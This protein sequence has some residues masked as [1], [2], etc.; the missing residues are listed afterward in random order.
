MRTKFLV[1]FLSIICSSL[2][3]KAQTR[4]LKKAIICLT[5]DD[6]LETQLSTVI[7]QLDS[8]GLK[9]TFFLNSINGSAVSAI[10]GKTPEA[11]I[12]WSNAAKHGHELGNHTLFHPCPEKLGWLKE[13]SIDN[14][15]VA[16]IIKE[17]ST[18][19]DILALL[20]PQRKVRSFAFPC[21]NVM[22]RD[23][24]YSKIIE[25]QGLAKFA[26]AGGDRN[27]II[28]DF[29]KLNTMQVPCWF[30]EP[31]TTLQEL[32]DFAEKT[33]KVSGLG[34]YQFHGVG[35]QVFK[36]TAETHR[37]FLAWLK[38]NEAN[39]H[40]TTFSNALEIVTKL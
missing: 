9:A 28:T 19:N 1:I 6:G 20:D 13:A 29:K 39:Y 23:T 3:V 26:R 38:K 36:I 12:G 22:I 14:Y 40:V 15:T 35:A 18:E 7:P 16:R 2:C 24:D 4:H 25:K 17:I 30:V 5:Y 32:I 34:I 11:V 33:K 21:N 27:S 8:V 31:G 10:P 37:A